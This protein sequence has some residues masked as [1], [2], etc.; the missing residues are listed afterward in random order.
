[1]NTNLRKAAKNNFEKGFFNLINNSV[2]TK[3]TENVEKNQRYKTCNNRKEKKVSGV[4]TKL[5]QYEVFLRI[6]VGYITEKNRITY[7]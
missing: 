5:S 1:M 3:T 2:F 4:R 6:F 7:K